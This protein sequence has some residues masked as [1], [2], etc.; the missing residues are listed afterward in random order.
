MLLQ[1]ASLSHDDRVVVAVV[2]LRTMLLGLK[3]P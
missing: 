2:S 3:M 1:A